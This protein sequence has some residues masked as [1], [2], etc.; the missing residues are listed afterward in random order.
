MRLHYLVPDTS[1]APAVATIFEM[2]NAGFGYGTIVARLT[3]EGFACP[4]AHDP[5]RN[6]H[7]RGV[8]S[9]SAILAILSNPRYT[10]RQVWARQRR[11]EVLID[12]RD[13]ALGYETK[14]RWNAQDKWVWSNDL[15]HE[16]LV[17]VEDFEAAQVRV[18]EGAKR[19]AETSKIHPTTVRPYVLRS[20]LRCAICDRRMETA[21]RHG[22][23]YYLCRYRAHEPRPAGHPT[24][25]YVREDD[26]LAVVDRW[27]SQC[28]HPDHLDETVEAMAAA[29]RQA[30][31]AAQSRA[32]VRQQTA[33]KAVEECE[34]ELESCRAALKEGADP[35]VVAKWIAETQARHL[36]ARRD[37]AAAARPVGPP[38]VTRDDLVSIMGL[39]GDALTAIASADPADKADVYAALG[40]A[41]SYDPLARTA[42][43]ECELDNACGKRPCR[44]GDLDRN[45]TARPP[46]SPA[47]RMRAR[48]RVNQGGAPNDTG[49]T[50]SRQLAVRPGTHRR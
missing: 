5:G 43:A 30:D 24:T 21:W 16:P 23:L 1:S 7:R 9:R 37:L 8:W 32:N 33:K 41:V 31:A 44:R 27:L 45:S 15:V 39:V 50:L 17:S 19:K 36:S 48:P 47:S 38:P 35:S 22:S 14:L 34:R 46:R 26:I 20:R 40:L 11:D 42:V 18:Q 28:L 13:V 10:G 29:T 25:A 12:V 2:F 3:R 49:V 6:R 4:S